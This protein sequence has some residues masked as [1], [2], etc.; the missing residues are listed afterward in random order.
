MFPKPRLRR[1]V[2][3]RY[4]QTYQTRNSVVNNF[5]FCNVPQ[6]HMIKIINLIA[7]VILILGCQNP[8]GKTEP[9]RENKY[10]MI[11]LSFGVDEKTPD[12][13]LYTSKVSNFQSKI[14]IKHGVYPD[15][16]RDKMCFVDQRRDTSFLFLIDPKSS[17]TDSI[18][19]PINVLKTSWYYDLNKYL[20]IKDYNALILYNSENNHMDFFKKSIESVC[21]SPDNIMYFVEE[22]D[23][24]YKS[25]P[26]YELNYLDLNT[27]ETAYL[28][29]FEES[30]LCEYYEDLKGWNGMDINGNVIFIKTMHS[31]LAIDKTTGTILDRFT[32]QKMTDL[33]SKDNKKVVFYSGKKIAFSMKKRKFS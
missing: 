33:I 29:A 7:V 17:Q 8:N 18:K 21:I 4:N 32:E 1:Q 16:Y 20:V 10:G 3:K 24:N 15:L 25:K 30:S 13:I 27:K 22:N 26:T 23:Q 6:I 11:E 9:I 14:I 19:L 5:I 2:Y 31:I 28:C 12:T